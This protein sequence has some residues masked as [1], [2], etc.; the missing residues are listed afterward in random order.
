MIQHLNRALK[1]WDVEI[2][3]LDNY[4]EYYR[5]LKNCEMCLV[6]YWTKFEDQT[7]D[8]DAAYSELCAGRNSQKI[9]VYFKDTKDITPELKNFKE[10][11]STKYGHFFC[12]FENV[13]TMI[14]NFLPQVDDCQNKPLE[15]RLKVRDLRVKTGGE[16][17]HQLFPVFVSIYD[18]K[19]SNDRDRAIHDP[20]YFDFVADTLNN[21]GC[22]HYQTQCFDKAEQEFGEALEIRRR[23]AESDPDIFDRDVAETLNKLAALHSNTRRFEKAE[24]EYKEAREKRRRLHAKNPDAFDSDVADTLNNLAILHS[25]TQR[26]DKAEQEFGEALKI[27]RCL[28]EK[29]PDASDVDVADTL[30]NLAILHSYTQRFD[31][32]EQEY[33]ETRKH[34]VVLQRQALKLST[35]Q[36]MRR[37]I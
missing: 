4:D 10:S 28:A 19:L 3:P 17:F 33:N 31:K 21:L 6:L 2:D 29:N 12:R 36:T 14:L 18:E 20:E 11:F 22:L 27:Y 32:A 37:T 5:K 24:Q 23:L 15:V 13:D 7:K 9:Y 1:P 35:V 26:F 34:V 16:A 25:C 8:E 30:N